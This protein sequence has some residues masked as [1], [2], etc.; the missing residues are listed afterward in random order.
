MSNLDPVS[1]DRES[2]ASDR[3]VV[4]SADSHAGASLQAYRQY[5]ERDWYDDFDIWAASYVDAW[6]E[7]DRNTSGV[8]AG[9]ASTTLE[10]NWNS[11]LRQ[12]S[13]E[14]DGIVGEVLFPNTV[15][16]F[17]PQEQSGCPQPRRIAANTIGVWLV[18]A[19]TTAG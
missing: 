18:S 12:A 15:P 2:E 1:F 14:S 13:V 8:R 3:C 7:L 11:D 4:V 6:A 17:S 9:L 5:L 10:T 16:P 19:P